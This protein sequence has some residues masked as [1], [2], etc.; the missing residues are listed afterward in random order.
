MRAA[1]AAVDARDGD[2]EV[3]HLLLAAGASPDLPDDS[4]TSRR[5]C[6]AQVADH[7]LGRF[8]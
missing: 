4:G 5:E 6:A 8:R 1:G 3:V 7:D 2:D